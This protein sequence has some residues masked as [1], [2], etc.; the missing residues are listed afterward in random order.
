MNTRKPFKR[1]PCNLKRSNLKRKPKK[2]GKL[3]FRKY[4]RKTDYVK[5]LQNKAEALWKKAGK[6]LHGDECEVKKNY[7]ELKI[8]HTDVI[9]GEHCI[10]RRN[11]YFFLDINNHSSACSACNQSKHY[12]SK[13]VDRAIEEI[14]KK[15][16]PQWYKDAVW[17]DQTR[18]ANPSW[19]QVWYLEEKIADL[20]EI[21]RQAS[22]CQYQL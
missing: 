10:S 14:V 3:T 7:P 16:N 18:E 11:K 2:Y 6:L 4:S 19:S 21:I 13:S 12:K 15:R 5:A 17:I 1:K 8:T 9:Q 22:L 20:E